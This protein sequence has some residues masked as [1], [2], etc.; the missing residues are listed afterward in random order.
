MATAER[1]DLTTLSL[2]E[3]EAELAALA[4]HLFAGMCR[5]LE[6]VGEI[7]RRGRWLD[8]GR[9]SC[10]EWLAWRCGLAPRAAR[11]HV[12]VAR[13]LPELPEIRS[14]FARGQLSYAKVRAL[15]RVA[16]AENES[17]LLSLARVLTA[18]Q[19]E[20][21]VRGYRRV[22]TEE[23]R[24]L[25]EGAYL[26]VYWDGDGSLA[27]HGRLAA[28]DGA[29]LLRALEAMRDAAWKQARG[30][31]E[32]R[33][34]RQAS[35]SEALV[36]V[37]DAALAH[38]ADGR[39]AGDRYQVVVHVDESALAHD[40]EGGCELEDGGALSAETARRLACDAS[41]VRNGRKRRSVPPCAARSA[42]A[43]AAA[44]SPPARTAASSTPT[45]S[46]TGPEAARRAWA[47]RC[48][49]AAVTTG[50]STKAATTPTGTD[51]STIRRAG[52]S[53]TLR[54]HPTRARWPCSSATSR[55]RT[56]PTRARPRPA[57]AY[58]SATPY[59]RKGPQRGPFQ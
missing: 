29:L 37:A 49:S 56:T 26:S 40:G 18:A 5:W 59:R 12:R 27:I 58:D 2:D 30:S 46:A 6:L 22:A 11:E 39:P 25:Q 1:A 21:A 57:S 47:T 52:G 9:A 38:S 20:R 19:L 51:A 50:S 42:R 13:R 32:P 41:V 4:S 28:E 16:T 55:S 54:S 10:A 35:R 24:D 45:T 7:D 3:L 34:A 33:P 31:A 17:D 8:E 15:T 36:A 53:P 43:T 44:A 48:C 14:A 23:S